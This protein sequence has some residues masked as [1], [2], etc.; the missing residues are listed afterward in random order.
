MREDFFKVLQDSKVIKSNSFTT[1]KGAY[2]I[3]IRRSGNKLY[4]FKYKNN[5]LVECMDLGECE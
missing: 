1:E 3:D 4:F 5:K 2:I